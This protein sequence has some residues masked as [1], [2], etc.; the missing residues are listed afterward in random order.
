MKHLQHTS[1]TSVTLKIN[2]CNMHFQAQHLLAAY[3]IEARW[4]VGFIGDSRIVATIG[5]RHDRPDRLHLPRGR[6]GTLRG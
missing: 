5:Q 1:K 6:W 3:E 2:A 4:C